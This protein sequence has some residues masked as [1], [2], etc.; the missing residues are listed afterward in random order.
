MPV[1]TST[2][3]RAATRNRKDGHKDVPQHREEMRRTL[4]GA[5]GALVPGAGHFWNLEFAD[6]FTQTLRAWIEDE[7]LPNRLLRI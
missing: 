1:S 2:W 3:F 7:P 4:P 5:R 6:L